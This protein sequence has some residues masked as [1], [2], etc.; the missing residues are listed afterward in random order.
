MGTAKTTMT[1]PTTPI[2]VAAPKDGVRGSAVID[3]NPAKAPFK[4]IVRSG[5]LYRNCVNRRVASAPPA[6]AAFVFD[7]M[8]E[9]SATSPT[10]PMANCE[11]PLNPNQPIHRINVPNVASV[12]LEPGIGITRPSFEYLPMRGPRMIAPAKA[13]QPPTECTTVEP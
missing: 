3:T 10:D 8:R 9:I 7:K 5:F 2:K 12:R 6:A 4:I 13:A 11:P 1:P